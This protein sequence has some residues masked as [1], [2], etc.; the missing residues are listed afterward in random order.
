SVL[1]RGSE[2][3]LQQIR[4]AAY[5]RRATYLPPSAWRLLMRALRNACSAMRTQS[6]SEFTNERGFVWREIV[7]VVGDTKQYGRE[8]VNPRQ[9]YEP[10][11]QKPWDT[12]TLAVRAFGDPLKL[13]SAVRAQ[14]QAIDKEQPVADIQTMEEIVGRSVGDRRF[15][16]LLFSAFAG[17]AVLLAAV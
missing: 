9:I 14:V 3:C 7:G 15:S 8:T 6:E 13:A 12:M 4:K 17:L 16:L 1:S 10:Y 5:S 2:G 11:L